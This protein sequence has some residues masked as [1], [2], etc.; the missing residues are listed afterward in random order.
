MVRNYKSKK[1]EFSNGKRRTYK[2]RS[3]NKF[4]ANIKFLFIFA[5]SL[6]VGELL[7]SLFGL[8]FN[9]VVY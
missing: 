5:V 6:I 4:L 9:I 2:K 3:E 8:I 1:T 7:Y